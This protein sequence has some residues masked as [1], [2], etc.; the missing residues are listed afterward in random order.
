[1]LLCFVKFPVEGMWI[2]HTHKMMLKVAE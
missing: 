1:M 2:L